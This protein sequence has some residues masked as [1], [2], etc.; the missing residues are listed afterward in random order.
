[1]V[2]AP[3]GYGKTT[4]LADWLGTDPVH[5]GW[6]SLSPVDNSDRWFWSIV[7]SSL[8]NC[9]I[10][11]VDNGLNDLALPDEPSRDPEF[12]AAV[13]NA[14]DGITEPLT[15]VLDNIQELTAPAA[16]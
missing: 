9:P 14:L 8:R 6:I 3:A 4:L 12:L 13:A 11:P 1:M 2:S 5:T 10:V 15:M 16:L 7:L